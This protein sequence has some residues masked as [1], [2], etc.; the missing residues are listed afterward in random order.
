MFFGPS[1]RSL[2]RSGA[3]LR[4]STSA[5]S[6]PPFFRVS[7]RWATAGS[8][9]ST[10]M[11]GSSRCLISD[12]IEYAVEDLTRTM[13]PDGSFAAITA[14]SVIE[15]GVEDEA[16]LAEYR[17]SL[18][19]GWHFRLLDGLLAG[20]GRHGGCFSLRSP[21]ADLQCGGDRGVPRTC[22]SDSGSRRYRIRARI[23]ETSGSAPFVSITAHTPFCTAC[24]FEVNA[25]ASPSVR[26][27]LRPSGL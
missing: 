5:V 13:R 22:R 17:P 20:E 16:L 10:S 14:I 11:L 19:T 8:R 21:M 12:E 27:V 3:K 18:A 26:Q 9:G 6:H 1:R 24:S 23:F 4:C 2:R 15:H 7:T 25:R